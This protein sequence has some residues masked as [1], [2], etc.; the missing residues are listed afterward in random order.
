MATQWHEGTHHRG[1]HAPR[2]RPGLAWPA[3]LDRRPLQA[4]GEKWSL[5]A[6]REISFGN[7]RFAAIA[8]VTGAPRDV[9]TARLRHL[10]SV[11]VLTRRQ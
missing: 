11:G 1:P 5:L 3:L 8:R 9:L 7:R 6:V 4:V 2:T 10:E